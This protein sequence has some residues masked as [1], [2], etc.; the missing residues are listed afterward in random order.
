MG[1]ND[2]NNAL[3]VREW[4]TYSTITKSILPC[5][6]VEI[7]VMVSERTDAMRSIVGP[8]TDVRLSRETLERTHATLDIVLPFTRVLVVEEGKLTVAMDLIQRPTQVRFYH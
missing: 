2:D 7:A 5:S 3:N 4:A 1:E 6:F 8:L